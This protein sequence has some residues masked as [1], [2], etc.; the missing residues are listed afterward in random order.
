MKQFF[1]SL[2]V[3]KQVDTYQNPTYVTRQDRR[4]VGRT[5]RAETLT[6]QIVSLKDGCVKFGTVVGRS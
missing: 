2:H 3:P 6:G 4:G 5:R 1:V